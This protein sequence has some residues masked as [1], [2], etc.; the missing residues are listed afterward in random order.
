M[1][2]WE[3]DRLGWLGGLEVVG[4][5]LDREYVLEPIQSSEQ[6]LKV[7]L[8]VGFPPTTSEY[9][10]IEY[11]AKEGFDQDLPSA[12][13]L[14][15]HID[16]KV[17][18][19]QPCDTCP[20]AYRVELLEADGNNTLRL[21]FLQGGNRGEPG[22]AWGVNGSG[23]LSNSTYPS[24]NLTS[25][26]SS[27]VTIYDITVSGGVARVTLSSFELPRPRLAQPLLGSPEEGLS[28]EEMGYLDSYGNQN[29]QYDVGD[30]RAYLKR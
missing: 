3:K 16:P 22:D 6:A 19:N 21:N 5:V 7:P 2:V 13:V 29:G 23:R 18:G 20:Q 24:T 27:P 8:E 10:L 15:Y 14:V 17:G 25:G 30:L 4:S 1:G 28:Q 9:L 11:R 12:G 26:T